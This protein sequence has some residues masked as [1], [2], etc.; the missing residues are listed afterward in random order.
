MAIAV[1]PAKVE[2]YNVPD[3]ALNQPYPYWLCTVDDE[4]RLWFY[5]AY[6]TREGAERARS[7]GT[8]QNNPAIV[9]RMEE[10]W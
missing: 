7:E 2:V 10:P 9:V 5:G 8:W 3:Y 1:R 6:R 4:C